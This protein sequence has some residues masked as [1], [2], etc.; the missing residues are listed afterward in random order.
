MVSRRA[1]F[2]N[3]LVITVVVCFSAGCGIVTSEDDK[4]LILTSTSIIAD[5][6]KQIGGEFVTVSSLIPIGADP[7]DFSPQ[8]K[9]AAAISEV[10][11]IFLNGAGLDDNLLPV[12][13]N[14]GGTD[15]VVEVSRGIDILVTEDRVLGTSFPDPHTWMDPNNIL[16]WLENITASLAGIDPGHSDKYHENSLKYSQD[17]TELDIWVRHQIE[18]IPADERLIVSDHNVFGYFNSTYGFTQVGTI[19]GSS[20]TEASPSA[21]DIAKLEDLIKQ[22]DIPAIFISE[23]SSTTL[24]DQIAFDTGI[25]VVQIYHGSLTT[26][27]GPVPSYLKFIRYNV[28]AIVE[29]LK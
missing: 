5:I 27:E 3:F 19:T 21:Q 24:V 17:I 23:T 16:I 10:D 26:K 11:I 12:I 9:E 14:A 2:I 22:H 8:P 4:L 15:K 13:E 25:K 6:V 28:T 18:I 29:A 20:S 1:R 7:H